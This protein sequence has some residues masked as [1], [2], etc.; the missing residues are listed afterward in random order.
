MGEEYQKGDQCDTICG[1]QFPA[2]KK[3]IMETR[4]T[5]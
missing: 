4:V 2:E 1:T 5:K 3:I